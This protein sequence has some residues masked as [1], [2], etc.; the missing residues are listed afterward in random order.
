M[1]L[2]EDSIWKLSNYKSP[3][4]ISWLKLY[5]SSQNKKMNGA[6]DGWN[7]TAYCAVGLNYES[8]HPLSDRKLDG[9]TQLYF[10]QDTNSDFHPLHWT[11]RKT[12]ETGEVQMGSKLLRVKKTHNK[13]FCTC[14]TQVS[15]RS[16]K[17]YVITSNTQFPPKVLEHQGQLI[18]LLCN[19]DI[20]LRA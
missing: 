5:N 3:P 12:R 14:C 15:L 8:L 4:K 13:C 17:K 18:F 1:W 9:R 11:S 19:E 10:R 20:S 6:L 2:K 16:L 7:K